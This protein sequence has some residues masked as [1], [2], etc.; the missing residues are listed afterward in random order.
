[1]K[2][3]CDGMEYNFNPKSG[4][5]TN[6]YGTSVA[7]VELAAKSNFDE[8]N[9]FVDIESDEVMT[10]VHENT[11]IPDIGRFLVVQYVAFNS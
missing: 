11:E 1:M 2:Y 7:R 6:N 9:Y 3:I 4:L 5:L 10:S 8:Y